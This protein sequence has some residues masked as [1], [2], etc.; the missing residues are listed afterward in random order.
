MVYSGSLGDKRDGAA[1]EV[2]HSL[3]DHSGVKGH[4]IMLDIFA[5]HDLAPEIFMGRRVFARHDDHDRQV[6]PAHF[7][8]VGDIATEDILQLF[9]RKILDAAFFSGNNGDGVFAAS[10]LRISV[11]CV[12]AIQLSGCAGN[13]TVIA[14]QAIYTRTGGKPVE[15]LPLSRMRV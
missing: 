1:R 12:S 8:S 11:N 7:L 9:F 15:H 2:F 3:N 6:R 10:N 14:H 13:I 5:F 4:E